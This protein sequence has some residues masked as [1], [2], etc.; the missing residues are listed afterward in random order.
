[1][2]KL[3]YIFVCFLLLLSCTSN[4]IL[5]PPKDLISKNK[6][7]AIFVDLQMAQSG[8]NVKNLQYQRNANYYQLVFDKYQI[9]TT[10]FKESNLY[11]ASL[12]D[13]YNAMFVEVEKRLVE[14][15]EKY[16]EDRRVEDS[17][18]EIE[19]N[20]QDLVS[21]REDL[22]ER[23]D[24]NRENFKNRLPLKRDSLIQ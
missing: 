16:M 2:T 8:K 22:K 4:T 5:N 18:Q 23:I 21:P 15:E 24:K 13:D 20:Q 6:M 14:L 7:I 1:M 10:Q 3:S 9:D 12:I 11:Y 19:S 17:I